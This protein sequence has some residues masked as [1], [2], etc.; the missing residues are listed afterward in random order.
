MCQ[1][2]NKDLPS[3]ASQ[4]VSADVSIGFLVILLTNFAVG[5]PINGLEG[6]VLPHASGCLVN[7]KTQTFSACRSAQSTS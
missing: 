6:E 3:V 2:E 7:F 1:K 4:T 5:V